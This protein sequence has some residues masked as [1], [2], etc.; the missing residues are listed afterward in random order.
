MNYYSFRI[1]II[2]VLV[3]IGIIIYIIKNT[4]KKINIKI[5]RIFLK[6]YIFY[7]IFFVI[8]IYNYDFEKSFITFDT[9]EDAVRY[10]TPET[11][12]LDYYE[13]DNVAMVYFEYK[14]NSMVAMMIKVNN[15][16]MYPN[17]N[18]DGIDIEHSDILVSP[19]CWGIYKSSDDINFIRVYS[20]LFEDVIVNDSLGNE[21]KN[22][23]SSNKSTIGYTFLDEVPENY[24]I[25]I[26]GVT[27]RV[28]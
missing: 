13:K 16:W 27:Y 8:F 28:N 22:L 12:F 2:F 26:N 19:I 10:R 4:S 1:L 7:S 3:V 18:Y 20:L 15:K 5:M 9:I 11:T 14:E 23:V 6:I 25:I 21:Y 17:L 24:Y